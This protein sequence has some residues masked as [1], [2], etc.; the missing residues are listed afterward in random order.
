[1]F[2]EALA[3]LYRTRSLVPGFD[4]QLGAEVVVWLLRPQSRQK[5]LKDLYRA[6]QFSEPTVRIYLM[7]LVDQGFVDIQRCADD[8]RQCIA[9]PTPKLLAAI[10]AYRAIFMRV[11]SAASEP[12]PLPD[13][14]PAQPAAQGHGVQALPPVAGWSDGIV[15]RQ[16]PTLP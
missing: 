9:E 6:S 2:W 12:T 15:R 5:P 3:E 1:M 11:A 7:R 16:P 10:E 13:T 4:T 14:V 8:Q